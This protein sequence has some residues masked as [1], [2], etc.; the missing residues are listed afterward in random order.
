MIER[1]VKQQTK[2]ENRRMIRKMQRGI[3]QKDTTATAR[4][5][6]DFEMITLRKIQNYKDHR[7]NYITKSGYLIDNYA[8]DRAEEARYAAKVRTKDPN[9]E[10]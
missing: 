2:A 10:K 7:G 5:P 6:M 8:I 9:L 1:R 3:I 4:A